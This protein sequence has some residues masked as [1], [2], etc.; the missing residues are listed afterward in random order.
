M[1]IYFSCPITGGRT[2]QQIYAD[3]V[4]HLIANG[5]EVLTAHLAQAGIEDQEHSAPAREVFRRDVA[6]VHDCDVVIAEVSTPSHGVG[7]EIAL[8]LFLIKPV[9]CCF[10]EGGRVSKMIVGNDHPC[11]SVVEYQ[12]AADVCQQIDDFLAMAGR[13][14]VRPTGQM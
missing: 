4:D 14:F 5:H 12:T 8:G 13:T 3:M 7:Y 11:L 2:D 10:R 6:W 9:L 1:K